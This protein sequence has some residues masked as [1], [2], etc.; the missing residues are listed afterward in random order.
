MDYTQMWQY[1]T[2]GMIAGMILQL[3]SNLIFYAVNSLTGF[4]RNII[5]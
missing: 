3:M 1:V 4:F 5:N 2:A